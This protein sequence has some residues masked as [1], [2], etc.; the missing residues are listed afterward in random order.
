MFGYTVA[1]IR[2]FD[3]VRLQT[4]IEKSA[5]MACQPGPISGRKFASAFGRRITGEGDPHSMRQRRRV[6]CE[7]CGSELVVESMGVHLQTQH[8]RSGRAMTLPPPFPIPMQNE[9]RVALPCT[10][11]SINCPVEDCPGRATSRTNLSLNC[12][13]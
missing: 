5:A 13:H 4:N 6:V 10:D 9:F 3:R 12:M 11:T 8:G 1:D 7:E 2:L